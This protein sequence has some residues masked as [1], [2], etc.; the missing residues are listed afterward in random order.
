MTKIDY[1]AVRQLYDE[2]MGRN[3]I[4][5]ELD[6]TQYEVDKACKAMGISWGDR[7]PRLAAQVRSRRAAEERAEIAAALR[8][9]ALSELAAVKNTTT[10]AKDR[11]AH[12]TT[13]GIAIQRD[14]DIAT[15]VADHGEH[16]ARSAETIREDAAAEEYAD[17]LNPLSV[18]LD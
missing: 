15:H 9:V 8:S 18:L 2:G 7:A 3:A 4:M 16:A 1:Q 6:A 10:S 17:M 14:L 12:M 13:A 11:Q 5:R